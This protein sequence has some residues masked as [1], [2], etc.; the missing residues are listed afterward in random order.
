[1]QPIHFQAP[2]SRSLRTTTTVVTAAL[3]AVAA[4]VVLT[5]VLGRTVAIH[6]WLIA[7]GIPIGMLATALPFSVRGYVLTENEIQIKRL[8]WITHL[9]FQTLNAV[10]GKADAMSNSIRAFG[11]GGFFAYTGLYWNRMLRF[12]RVYA[13]DPS[14]AVILR[15][16]DKTV[17]ITPHD[18]QAF[19]MRART[20]IKTR[21]FPR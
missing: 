19:I 18:P 20:L 21:D 12:Y 11:N 9:P 2:W 17:V 4:S 16:P 8:G 7:V 6:I 5:A 15:Y 1:M 13:T 10:E 14:R 3:I